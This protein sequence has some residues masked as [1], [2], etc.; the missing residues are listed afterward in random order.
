MS[1]KGGLAHLPASSLSETGDDKPVTASGTSRR[2]PG[3][4]LVATASSTVATISSAEASTVSTV[5]VA[6][7]RAAEA[8]QGREK[9]RMEQREI[10]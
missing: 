5:S 4:L 10:E 2:V 3:A 9:V 7:R 6:A 1:E 8:D